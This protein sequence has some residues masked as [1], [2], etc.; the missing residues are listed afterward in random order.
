M[1]R[2][3]PVSVSGLN[4]MVE[5]GSCHRQLNLLKQP[6]K[7]P[8]DGTSSGLFVFSTVSR[9]IREDWM[10]RARCDK[11]RK[12]VTVKVKKSFC[13]ARV[14]CNNHKT[15]D[16]NRFLYSRPVKSALI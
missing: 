12:Q 6:K 2:W 11:V 7:R 9:L 14:G 16:P 8:P 15:S 3:G 10:E 1:K 13:Q 5:S 4:W